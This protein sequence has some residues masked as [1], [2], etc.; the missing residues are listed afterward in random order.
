MY[1][2]MKVMRNYFGFEG[3]AT[4]SEY[5]Y[6]TM[7][8]LL[9]YIGASLIDIILMLPIASLLYGIAV[10]FPGSAVFIRRLHDVGKSGWWILL[11]FIPVIGFVILL[12]YLVQDS[13][14]D[15]EYGV[16]PKSILE[17]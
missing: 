15:N 3:R 1:W 6:F 8:N 11:S 4:R 5:W 12:Y 10:L 16:N 7:F 2:Y 9:F 13:H 14:P 17:S